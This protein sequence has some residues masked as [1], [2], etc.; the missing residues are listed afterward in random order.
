VKTGK[1]CQN[2][3]R[4]GP[5]RKTLVKQ[6]TALITLITGLLL[7][8]IG[9]TYVGTPATGRYWVRADVPLALGMMLIFAGI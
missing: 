4:F 7:V 1:S 3:F 8:G 6:L 5:E 9:V 2:T